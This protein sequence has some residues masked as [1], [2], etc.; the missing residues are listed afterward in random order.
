M[1]VSMDD[2]PRM[3]TY[4]RDYEDTGYLT[5][6]SDGERIIG[7]HARR[8]RGRRVARPGD[9]RDS[10]ARAA[11]GLRGHD[12]AVS[13]LLRGLSACGA[14]AQQDPGRRVACA[15]RSRCWPWSCWRPLRPAT[16]VGSGPARPGPSRPDESP[17][18]MLAEPIQWRRSTAVGRPNAGRLV[19]GVQLPSEGEHFFTWDPIRNTTPNRPWRRYGTDR[20][21]RV[22]LQVLGGVPGRQSR[23][24][25]HRHRRPLATARRELRRAVRRTRARVPPERARRRRLLPARRR[26]RAR[27]GEC[28][29]GRPRARPGPRDA[30]RARRREVRVR[31]PTRRPARP[32]PDRAGDPRARQPPAR[33][34]SLV[35]RS[36]PCRG[37]GS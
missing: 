1:T 7:A 13:D 9:A 20:L 15:C 31:R 26:A 30:L 32:A 16:A 4:Y 5:L 14:G 35:V 21:M 34:D 24:A 27:P 36:S 22:L 29:P 11:R 12:P 28:R 37:T 17:E 6:V 10:R 3:S 8:S 2:V 18:S 25:A 23:R 19:N 33:P